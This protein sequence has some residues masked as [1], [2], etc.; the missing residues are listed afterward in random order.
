MVE[1]PL[2]LSLLALF[3]AQVSGVEHMST[4]WPS[5][6]S[7]SELSH[8]P[9]LK[10]CPLTSSLCSPA[11]QLAVPV[12][13][14]L[15]MRL[16]G[17]LHGKVMEHWSFACH[18]FI[19]CCVFTVFIHIVTCDLRDHLGLSAWTKAKTAMLP[20]HTAGSASDREPDLCQ[21]IASV[22]FLIQSFKT[23]VSLYC[24]VSDEKPAPEPLAEKQ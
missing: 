16:L 7:I 9:T 3:S 6:L 5:P 8:F 2:H 15:Y 20:A 19:E 22:C 4:V 11:Q 21:T 24:R 23:P 18:L 1:F 17:T 14:W 13:C 10:P 12:P